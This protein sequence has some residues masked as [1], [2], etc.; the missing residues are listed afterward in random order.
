MVENYSA[1]NYLENNNQTCFYTHLPIY[2]HFFLPTYLHKVLLI[3]LYVHRG[4]DGVTRRTFQC[5]PTSNGRSQNKYEIIM[6]LLQQ[7][8]GPYASRLTEK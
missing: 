8:G 7:Q 3:F 2:E 4:L 5:G 6:D 1:T